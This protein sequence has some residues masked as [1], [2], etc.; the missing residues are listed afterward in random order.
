MVGQRDAR[1]DGVTVQQECLL[2]MFL[3]GIGIAC[4]AIALVMAWL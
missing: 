3:S 4:S 1:G 2:A